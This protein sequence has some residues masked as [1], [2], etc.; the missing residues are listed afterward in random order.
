MIA[1]ALTS[2]RQPSTQTDLLQIVKATFASVAAW[3][4][5]TE[6]FGLQQAFLAAWTA[7]LTVNA[8]VYRSFLH[9]AQSVLATV[10]GVTISVVL[11]EV[12]GVDVVTL[13]AALL[14]GL[15]LASVGF[16]RDERV[17]VATTALFVLTTGYERQESM[18]GDRFADTA[19]GV[20]IGLLVNLLVLPPLTHRSAEQQVEQVDN[21]LGELLRDM[22]QHLASASST[23]QTQEWIES[24]RQIDAELDRGWQLVH[25][26]D[27]SKWW[28]PR[29]KLPRRRGTLVGFG[30]VLTRLEDGV[31]QVRAIARVVHE[32]TL[33][34][35]EWDPRFRDQWLSLLD[36]LG[37]R[38]ADPD[39]DVGPLRDDLA[40]LTS[41]L[42]DHELPDTGWPVY[43]ALLTATRI[44][45]DV[46]DDVASARPVRA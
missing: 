8:T 38:V 21:R 37:E 2:L 3:V 24:S 44:I 19:V 40:S 43:G 45:V 23:D 14:L 30:E 18:L 12:M 13:A 4:V 34:A 42:S 31:A 17:T 26:A 39:R 22:A 41:E 11:A 35:D 7:L 32:S 29:A 5:A 25:Q 15:V 1:R 46:V 33:S 16:L 20:V 28:N 9:G 10:L 27:E 6:V 36:D